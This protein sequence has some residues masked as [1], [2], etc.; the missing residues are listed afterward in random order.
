MPCKKW[1]AIIVLKWRGSSIVNSLLNFEDI[2]GIYNCT[3]LAK[4]LLKWILSHYAKHE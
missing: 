3:K 4:Q 2:P 1:A